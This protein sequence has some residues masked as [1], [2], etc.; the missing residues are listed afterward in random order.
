MYTSFW[1]LFLF[2]TILQKTIT[3]PIEQIGNKSYRKSYTDPLWKPPGGAKP[4]GAVSFSPVSD[5]SWVLD[6]GVPVGVSRGASRASS[7]RREDPSNYIPISNKLIIITINNIK[8]IK[9]NKIRKHDNSRN[10][11]S[12]FT[13]VMFY[14]W[15]Y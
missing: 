8:N 5:W 14:F 13:I 2:Y 6:N 4:C 11:L 1:R 12:L 15:Y 10:V 7:R 9:Y 3:T